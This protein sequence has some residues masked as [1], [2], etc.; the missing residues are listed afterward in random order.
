[1][2]HVTSHKFLRHDFPIFNRRIN[3]HPLT[4]LDSASTSQK[5]KS[6]I[7]AI[8]NFYEHTNANI[9]R[10]IYPLSQEATQ[11]YEETR[12]AVRKFI[13]ARSTEEIIFTKNTS[14]GINLI[15]YT[16]GQK[17][18]KKGDIVLV[19]ALEHHSNLVP[20]QMLCKKT[21]AE[22]QVIPLN[23]DFGLDLD[24]AE[25]LL[26]EKVKLL[27]ITHA[28]NITGAITSIEKLT[29]KAREVGAKILL[30]GAQ[31][32]PHMKIDV[33]KFDCD[34]FAFSSHK[35]LGPTGVGVLY[36]KKELLESMPPFL[37]GGDMIKEVHQYEASWNDLPWKFEAGTP[38]IADVIV[39]KK[40]LEYLENIGMEKVLEHDQM[41]LAYAKQKLAEL[42]EIE[43][44]SPKNPKE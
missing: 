36:G 20:W 1:M 29:K 41:L 5:P 12:E 18:I 17:N 27:A 38:N 4:Y 11:Q 24:A 31:S 33:Q 16:W 37:F 13:N 39:F 25:K 28:S 32:A 22:L 34:F 9:H 40:A 10:G 15:A 3:G 14:E 8:V 7:D 35:M 2:S 42:P 26:T 6:V 44:Y 19:S 23:D 43:T 21:G 30:D